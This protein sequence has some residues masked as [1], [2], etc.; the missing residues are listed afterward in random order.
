MTRENRRK[1]LL[2]RKTRII[3]TLGMA[4]L[5]PCKLKELIRAGMDVA[6]L[7]FSYGNQR[8]HRDNIR[9]LRKA[10]RGVHRRVAILQ[11]LSGTKVRLRQFK[12]QW[13][14]LREKSEFVL[15][16]REVKGDTALASVNRPELVSVIRIGDEVLLNDGALRLR[17]VAKTDT[18]ICCEVLIGG[19]IKQGQAVHVPGRSPPVDVPTQKDLEDVLFGLEQEVDW[20]A[21]SYVRCAGEVRRLRDFIRNHGGD[22]PIM[23]KIERSEA[24]DDLDGIIE[25]ADG[26]MVARGDL[27]LEVPIEKIALIQK[28]IIRRAN[29]AGKPVV[30]ATEMLASMMEH[31]RPTRAEVTD[32]TNAIL[33]GSDGV[34]LSGES[35]VGQYPVEATRM[36]ARVAAVADSEAGREAGSGL[37]Q[38]YRRL[39]TRDV[40]SFTV[41]GRYKESDYDIQTCKQGV[42]ALFEGNSRVER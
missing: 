30:T 42:H 32:I 25:A 5:A 29:T 23:A 12:G 15:T 26:I 21:E 35:A 19:R 1:R 14:T 39:L 7:H 18:D 37:L 16:T 11:D 6:R 36:M 41:Y 24:L 31:P 20:I 38:A 8:Q 34:M 13:V 9:R 27:G 2:S 22:T 10:A 28:E 3:C 33:D 17:V 40:C 4:S